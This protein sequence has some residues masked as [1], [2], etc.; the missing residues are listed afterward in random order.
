MGR[1]DR[2]GRRGCLPA[3]SRESPRALSGISGLPPRSLS[4]LTGCGDRI[5][6]CSFPEDS[7]QV[8]DGDA[9]GRSG[10]V[11]EAFVPVTPQSYCRERGRDCYR[12]KN[13]FLE[14]TLTAFGPQWGGRHGVRLGPH[15][16]MGEMDAGSCMRGIKKAAKEP[17]IFVCVVGIVGFRSLS[18]R[19]LDI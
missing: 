5:S 14:G 7:G 11:K 18:R 1:R 19:C 15:H 12:A 13:N 16:S 4:G 10:G 2:E 6:L 17:E 9:G 8:G 3:V